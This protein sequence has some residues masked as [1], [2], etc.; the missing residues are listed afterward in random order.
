MNRI[1]GVIRIHLRDKLSILYLPWI[2]MMISFAVNLIIGLLL[3]GEEVIYTGG[4][5]SLYVYMFVIGILTLSQTFPFALGFSVRRK[6]YFWGTLLL[7]VG[8][9]AV[10]SA[11]LL[12]L[13]MTETHVI[14]GWGV[15]LHFFDIPYLNDGPALAR[16]WVPFVLLLHMF[17]LG[18]V[19][20]GV[21]R[22][23]GK[24]GLW[25]VMLV[26]LVLFSVGIF[27]CTY[28]GWWGTVF[29]WFAANSMVQLSLWLFALALVYMLVSYSLLR[30]T[31]I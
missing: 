21:F 20:S 6:D 31:T 28:Y 13:G 15:G 25:S 18:F 1:Q 4:I 27:A 11:V 23:F 5:A 9:S 26:M 7:M 12:L 3:R 8:I 2:I 24:L 29:A 19:I 16:L 14:A 30:R 10:F 22:R 17:Y